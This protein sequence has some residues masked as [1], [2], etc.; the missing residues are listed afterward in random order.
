[1]KHSRNNMKIILSMISMY[2]GLLRRN[3]FSE[4]TTNMNTMQG[5]K[6]LTHEDTARVTATCVGKW[7]EVVN[8]LIIFEKEV[9]I[10]P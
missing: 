8:Y 5:G 10:K 7:S 6:N 3:K 9:N 4:T 1:M 2:A